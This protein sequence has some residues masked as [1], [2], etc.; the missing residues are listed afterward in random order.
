MNL[1]GQVEWGRKKKKR[2]ETSERP[3]HVLYRGPHNG[4]KSKGEEADAV[5]LEGVEEEAGGSRS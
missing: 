4:R 1:K 3:V 2:R 5:G